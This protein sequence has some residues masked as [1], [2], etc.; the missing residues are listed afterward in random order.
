MAATL[1]VRTNQHLAR[2]QQYY[3]DSRIFQAEGKRLHACYLDLE[4]ES[5]HLLHELGP[6]RKRINFLKQIPP[7]L[8]DLIVSVVRV[9]LYGISSLIY[10]MK[11]PDLNFHFKDAF[12]KMKE[13]PLD[14]AYLLYAVIAPSKGIDAYHDMQLRRT[15]M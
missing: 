10:C 3:T 4:K 1:D 2:S 12:T 7:K 14:I 11:N 8:I 13:L 15:Q 6:I 5:N 9:A